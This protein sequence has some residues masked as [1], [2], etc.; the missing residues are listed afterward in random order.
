MRWVR[1]SAGGF[2]FIG[3]MG[4]FI[5]VS[6]PPPLKVRKLYASYREEW[7]KV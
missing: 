3:F 6:D 2:F 1:A 5:H 4:V 7:K